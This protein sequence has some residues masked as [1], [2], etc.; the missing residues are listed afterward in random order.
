M[1]PPPLTSADVRAYRLYAQTEQRRTD[2]EVDIQLSADQPAAPWP[3]GRHAAT[4]AS[5]GQPPAGQPPAGQPSAS[6]EQA[7]GKQAA[8]EQAAGKQAAGKQAAGEQAAGE[9]AAGEASPG[10]PG[11]R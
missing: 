3:T 7:A 11:G 10:Q 8:G 2:Y 1:A 9:Q 5:G 6:S 4:A